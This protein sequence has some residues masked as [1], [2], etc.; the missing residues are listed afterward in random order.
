MKFRRFATRTGVRPLHFEGALACLGLIA[1]F[2]CSPV[3]PNAE[4]PRTD[5]V[6]P[7]HETVSGDVMG[8][9][10]TASGDRLSYSVRLRIRSGD[11]RPVAVDLAPASY[12][13]GPGFA[14]GDSVELETVEARSDGGKTRRLFL[15]KL[16]TDAQTRSVEVTPRSN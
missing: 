4:R 7:L 8:I 1:V 6:E 11:G 13:T 5:F 10:R 14:R 3:S 9:D 12:G 15:R 16:G 2:G